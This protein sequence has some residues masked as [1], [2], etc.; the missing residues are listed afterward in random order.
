[1]LVTVNGTNISLP[2]I[3]YFDELGFNEPLMSVNTLECRSDN[4]ARVS[5][6]LPSDHPVRERGMGESHFVQARTGIGVTPSRSALSQTIQNIVRDDDLT[7]GL[8]N[9]RLIVEPNSDSFDEQITIGIYQ[10]GSSEYKLHAKNLSEQ[11]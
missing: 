7:N 1:M 2:Y 5:W 9:C 6:H 8:W 4:R 3:I 11:E 10:R